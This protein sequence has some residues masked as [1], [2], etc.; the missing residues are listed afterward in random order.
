MKTIPLNKE[1]FLKNLSIMEDKPEVIYY[2]YIC[3]KD[4][5]SEGRRYIYGRSDKEKPIEE[6]R[7]LAEEMWEVAQE[8]QR[9][10]PKLTH[11]LSSE[12]IRKGC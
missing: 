12:S 10:N 3:E 11:L 9:K 5:H 2:C 1:N 4:F 6:M 7:G 8:E